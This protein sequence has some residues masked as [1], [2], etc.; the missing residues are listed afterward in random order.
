[1]KELTKLV[2]A[3]LAGSL[4]D[5]NMPE[6]LREAMKYSLLAGGK[7]LRPVLCL[8]C[9][10][11]VAPEEKRAAL[12]RA[13]LPFAAGL[14]MIHTYSLI[15]DDLPSMDNDDLRRGRP[16]CHKAFDEATALLA[17]DALLTDS[18]S[19]M[20][21]AGLQ[22]GLDPERVLSALGV[23]AEAAGSR[24]MVGGQV[25]DIACTGL[26]KAPQRGDPV[27]VRQLA[28]MQSMKTG[29]LFRAACVSGGYL[30]GANAGQIDALRCYAEGLGA[31]FQIVDDILD[32]TQDSATLGKPSGSDAALGKLT[33][34]ALTSLEESR[35][36]A[37]AEAGRAV[38]ALEDFCSPEADTL[39]ALA[40]RLLHRVC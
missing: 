30:G 33:W 1:M 31:A 11:A 32:E 40:E 18:F 14:E 3:Y 4:D 12:R 13:M 21:R 17:G 35:E 15:H 19:F 36:R 2:E 28:L 37:A 34:P 24:G 38:S 7:R 27:L 5:L 29:A 8:L 16:S 9:G 20:A 22:N 39:R 10:G 23:V 25:L 6:Q 26:G